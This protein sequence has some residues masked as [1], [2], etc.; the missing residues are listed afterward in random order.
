MET[1]SPAPEALLGYADLARIFDCCPKTI[2]RR[3]KSGLL[4]PPIR[5]GKRHCR[6]RR[7]DIDRVVACGGSNVQSEA[8]R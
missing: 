3:W 2:S 6:W 4:P 1:P 5:C 8:A 7:A